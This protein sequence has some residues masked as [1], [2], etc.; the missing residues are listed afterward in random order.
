M[1]G[2]KKTR[3]IQVI[4]ACAVFLALATG[5]IGFALKDGNNLFR[6]PSQV[7]DDPPSPNVI[8]RLGGLVKQGSL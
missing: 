4:V 1:K 6:A 3:R 8:F 7:L 2:L 5:L